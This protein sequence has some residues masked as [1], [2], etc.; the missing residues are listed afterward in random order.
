MAKNIVFVMHGI[1]EY[2]QDWL[3]DHSSAA[4]QLRRAAKDYGFF[5]GKSLDTY[6][7]FVPI[8]YDDVFK[9]I[10]KH[11]H[12]LGG[13]LA[14]A[15][16][17]MPGAAEKAVNLLQQADGDQWAIQ[18]AGD[19]VL[20]W[21]FRL[22]QQRVILRVLAQITEKIAETITADDV[23]PGYHV[24]AHSLGTAVA[25]DALH[26]L[27]TEDWLAALKQA[28]LD[29]DADAEAKAERDR[30]VNS[31]AQ[32][33][34]KLGV[35]NPL[36]PKRFQFESVTMLSNVSGLIHPSES[37]YHSIV[38][39][40]TSNDESAY[41]QNYVNVNHKYDPVSLAGNFKMP[42]SW[43]LQGGYDLRVDHVLDVNIHGAAHYVAHPNV[44]LRLLQFYV[45]PYAAGS[46]DLK[47]IARFQKAHGIENL[48]ADLKQQVKAL[49]EIDGEGIDRLTAALG[50][51][52]ALTG[53]GADQ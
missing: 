37:P 24:L 29:A 32:L 2:D 4:Y 33:R 16:P 30:Y 11:W 43:T 19:V 18:F 13:E 27:G 6:V 52:Q 40:G 45:D 38:R 41:T 50:K 48:A 21:G 53:K 51:L 47:A 17:N 7:E 8:L 3:A 23:V 1:G 39:P 35:A 25:H 14:A 20:Y 28:P 10:L 46:E 12:D 31:V 36:H 26:H 15:V 44:H 49:V 42:Q 22:F 5:E 34:D 9:R